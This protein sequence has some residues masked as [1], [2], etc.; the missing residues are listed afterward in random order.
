MVIV[1][2]SALITID[3]IAEP[4]FLSMASMATFLFN[5]PLLYPSRLLSGE[6][7]FD[8]TLDLLDRSESMWLA[9]PT[10]FPG[11]AVSNQAQD[12]HNDSREPSARQD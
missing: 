3:P 2:S 6:E 8:L 4:S 5:A 1:T 12:C 10:D 7:L 9:L 11:V